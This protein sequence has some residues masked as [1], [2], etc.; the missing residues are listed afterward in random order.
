MQNREELR[1]KGRDGSRKTCRERGKKSH[2]QKDGGINIVFGPKYRPLKV[3]GVVGDV[4]EGKAEKMS[5]AE[6]WT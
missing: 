1:E 4:V 6:R 5:T 3:R 2:F